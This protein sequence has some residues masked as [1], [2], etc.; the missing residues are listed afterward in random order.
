M[1]IILPPS[2]AKRPAPE[3]G[4][5]L[6]LSELSFPEL[7]QARERVLNALVATSAAPDAFERLR[8]RPT[9][10]DDVLSNLDLHDAPTRRAAELYVGPLHAGFGWSALS[11]AAKRTADTEVVIASA[12]W[13]VVRPR[14]QI[15]TYRLHICANLCDFGDLEPFWRKSVPDV[16]VRAAGPVGVVLDLRSPTYQAMGKPAGLADR[17]ISIRVLPEPGARTIGDVVAKRMRGHIARHLVE[18]PERPSTPDDLVDAITD[19]WPARLEP[20]R[21]GHREWTVV[22]RP[23]D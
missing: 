19:R 15:P 1:L 2:E 8:V 17:T 4:A 14:D 12:L 7:N 10:A 20:P 21:P 5:R 22:V 6:A 11:D 23:D 18:S 3:D 13:G 16:L 9:L